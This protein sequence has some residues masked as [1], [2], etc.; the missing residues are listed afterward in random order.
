[1]TRHA[2]AL[3]ALLAMLATVATPAVPA[4]AQ[5]FSTDDAVLSR[6]WAE[7]MENSQASPLPRPCST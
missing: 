7:G 1:M 3:G 6:L 4:A 2:F 5:T